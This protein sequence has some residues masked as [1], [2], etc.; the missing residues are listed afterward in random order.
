VTGPQ[1][2]EKD[3]RITIR[4]P[5]GP[6]DFV[7]IFKE[8]A[9]GWES[10]P[11]GYLFLRGEIVEPPREWPDFRVLYARPTGQPGEYSLIG[12]KTQADH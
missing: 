1:L 5:G 6:H 11:N 9:P 3:E 12:N 8:L 4:W 10:G 2:P 7:M